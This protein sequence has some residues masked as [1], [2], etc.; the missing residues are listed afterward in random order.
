MRSGSAKKPELVFTNPIIESI[1]ETVE[2]SG[3]VTARNQ[4]KLKFLAGGKL[5]YLGVK[6]GDQVKKYQRIASIDARDLQ[7]N[8]KSSLNSYLIERADL[9]EGRYDNKDVPMTDS[10]I[11]SLSQLQWTMDNAVLNVELNDLAIR[12]S[13]LYSPFAGVVTFVPTNT[14][15]MQVTATDAFEIV[16]PETIEFAGEVDEIDIGRIKEGQPVHVV[17]DAY[18]DETTDSVVEQVSLKATSSTKSSGGTVFLVRARLPA[19]YLHF[20]LGMNGTMKIV[21]N[22][23]SNVLTIPLASVI[24]RD[25]KRLVSVKDGKK[26]VEK[27]IQTG[28]E[29]DERIEVVSGISESDQIVE[30]Q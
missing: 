30:I 11:R 2:I 20:R 4:A 17:L 14:A 8:L 22:K 9:E 28:I 5:T 13:S 24:E 12:N 16:D 3:N 10:V 18:L 6:E 7:K 19:D 26:T 23:A 27:E 25:G 15:G 21:T 1:E 29:S